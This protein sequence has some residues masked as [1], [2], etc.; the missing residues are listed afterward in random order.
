VPPPTR[1][2]EARS[3]CCPGRRGRTHGRPARARA[4]EPRRA[5]PCL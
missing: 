2:A 1:L 3:P 5:E 4:P